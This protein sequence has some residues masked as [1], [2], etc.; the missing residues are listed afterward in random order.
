MLRLSLKAV[1][2]AAVVAGS[3]QAANAQTTLNGASMFDEEHA[4]TK[5]LREFE[6]LVGEK[7]DG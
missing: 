4:F 6:R 1:A 3:V 7:Y 2:V 5:T